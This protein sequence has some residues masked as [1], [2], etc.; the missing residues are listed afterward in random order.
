MKPYLP[1]G[2]L[3]PSVFRFFHD[4]GQKQGGSRL[5]LYAWVSPFK[6]PAK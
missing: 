2:D 3:P 6:V 1:L 5:C 4:I